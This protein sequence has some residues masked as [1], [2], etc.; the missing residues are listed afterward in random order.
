[1][2]KRAAVIVSFMKPANYIITFLLLTAAVSTNAQY[3]LNGSAQQINCHC[4]TL[5]PEELTK[6]GSV[7]HS[8]KI[9]LHNSFD[10]WFNVFLG[11]KDANGADGIVFML[12]PLSTSVGATGEGMGFNGI[13]PSI[14]IAL[15]TWQNTN[16]N[17]PPYDHI[18]IQSNGNITHGFDLA[19]PVPVSDTSDNVEDCKWHKLRISW[20][21]NN[22][23]LRTYFDDVLRV[24]KKVNLLDSIF[25]STPMVYWGFSAATGGAVNL[26]QFCTALTAKFTTNINADTVCI[27][28]AIRF[29]DQSESFAPLANYYWNF[30]D[31]AVSTLKDPPP[32]VY[33]TAGDYFIKYAVTA[34]DGCASDTVKKKIFIA[35]NPVA[36]FSIADV[37][38]NAVP[39]INFNTV[40]YAVSY[41]WNLNG[42]SFSQQ[43]QPPVNTLAPGSYHLSLT[44]NSTAGCGSPSTTSDSFYIF[45][46]PVI[47]A[48]IQNGCVNENIP[49]LGNQTDSATTINSWHWSF[50][51][52]MESTQQSGNIVFHK[53]TVLNIKTWAISNQGCTSDTIA[54]HISIGKPFIYAGDDTTILGNQPFQLN[55]IANGSVLWTPPTG[56][57]NN[58][59][60][61]PLVNLNHDQGYEVTVTTPEGCKASDSLF[62]KIFKG[63]FVYAPNAFTP[64]GD[65]L[66]DVFHINY[67]GVKTVREL[68]IFNRWGELIY[69]STDKNASWNGKL[70][71]RLQ[72]AGT[73]VWILNAIDISGKEHS[74]KGLVTMIK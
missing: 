7:W 58:T 43:P 45:S 15:D 41:N 19:G 21:A 3:I 68:R 24:E 38:A 16:L 67:Q 70:N 44:L 66:N 4:Y 47:T 39:V 13:Q 33:N 25:V 63:G 61:T 59:I 18:S 54:N 71:G 22:F 5:T 27:G 36:S 2:G 72:P 55:V 57:D 48:V 46:R 35:P 64:N 10:F 1:M 65:G 69:Y 50:D 52:G 28:T 8:T 37:C 49:F 26:Q 14:G 6:S 32:H 20:D 42:T 56:L 53:P 23:W 31:G 60:R 11:C 29:Q 17:D 73:Y 9:D 51:N 12:Q 40:N 30:G 62:I 74:L 34:L